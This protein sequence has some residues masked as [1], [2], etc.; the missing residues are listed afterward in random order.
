MTLKLMSAVFLDC[1]TSVSP[2][3]GGGSGTSGG[4]KSGGGNW[5]IMQLVEQDMELINHF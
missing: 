3:G 4:S 1:G 5:Q 2:S